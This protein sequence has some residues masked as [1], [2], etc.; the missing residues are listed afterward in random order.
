M[1]VTCVFVS[2]AV[3]FAGHSQSMPILGLPSLPLVG[4]A[5]NAPGG[6][7]L[8][9]GLG[10][11]A[12]PLTSG[13]TSKVGGLTHT[14]SPVASGLTGDVAPVTSRLGGVTHNVAPVTSD[15]TGLTGGLPD[16]NNV[17][18]GLTGQL[19]PATSGLTSKL[20]GLTD[21]VSPVTSGLS[22]LTG[23]LPD[24]QN[25]ASGLPVGGLLSSLV[26][27]DPQFDGGLP[28]I[29]SV[30]GLD[31]LGSIMPSMDSLPIPSMDSLPGLSSLESLPVFPSVQLTPIL[32]LLVE[33]FQ[34]V[35]AAKEG[36][37][38]EIGLDPARQE[39]NP[40]AHLSNQPGSTTRKKL[41][42]FR[43]GLSGFNMIS[44]L[45]AVG[46]QYDRWFRR[47]PLLTLAVA[48]G[49][50][51]ILGDSAAQFIKFR[52]NSIVDF[53]YARLMRYL[54]YGINMGPVSGKWNEFLERQFP[55]RSQRLNRLDDLNEKPPSPIELL[56]VN[57]TIPTDH[58]NNP[59]KSSSSRSDP[60]GNSLDLITILK[61][62]I[63]DFICFM[64]FTE[65]NNWEVIYARLNRLFLK[66]LLA[67]WQ[68]WPIIQL[69]AE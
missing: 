67:N 37:K 8:V 20:G 33:V 56:E 9:G 24:I 61:M 43:F 64:G 11:A 36:L 21:N 23:G 55:A 60:T 50:C 1:R 69:F 46:H 59:S 34:H 3:L 13:L 2:V 53:K 5:T 40:S 16:V 7:P 25:V 35:E 45:R 17:A 47:S 54:L 51:S 10:N 66:L 19:A 49:I 39:Q 68:V 30:P 41:P 22:G 4:D 26:K 12:S 28:I 6:L 18:S 32:C 44:L 14:V 42:I 31:S 29:G 63:T 62:V 27:R 38:F 15:V 58:E 65:G 52:S 57:S 48:N